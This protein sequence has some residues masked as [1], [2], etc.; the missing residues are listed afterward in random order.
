MTL[1]AAGGATVSLTGVLLLGSQ[2]FFAGGGG[3][4]GGTTVTLAGV[5]AG[6]G[7]TVTFAAAVAVAGKLSLQVSGATLYVCVMFAYV[8][9]TH[10]SA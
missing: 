4:G 3:G 10:T 2:Y 5:G 8:G 6:T 9:V 7:A 1:S